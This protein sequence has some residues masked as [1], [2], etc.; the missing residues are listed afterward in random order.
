MEPMQYFTGLV[1]LMCAMH[2]T[3]MAAEAVSKFLP[4]RANDK[5]SEQPRSD[6][7][8]FFYCSALTG[9]KPEQRVAQSSARDAQHK[10]PAAHQRPRLYC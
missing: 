2:L 4:A 10:R 6:W 9:Q 8:T 5:R 7:Y 1:F 3:A